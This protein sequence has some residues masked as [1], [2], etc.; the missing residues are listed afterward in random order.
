VYTE[1][2]WGSFHKEWEILKK[3]QT[4]KQREGNISSP[5]PL[6]TYTPSHLPFFHSVP[7]SLLFFIAILQA[8]TLT[9]T[10]TDALSLLL[11]APFSQH[12]LCTTET[13]DCFSSGCSIQWNWFFSALA[14]AVPATNQAAS[15]QPPL[16]CLWLYP[17]PFPPALYSRY[18]LPLSVRHVFLQ[19]PACGGMKKREMVFWGRGDEAAV[20]HSTSNRLVLVSLMLFFT[21]SHRWKELALCLIKVYSSLWWC[22]TPWSLDWLTDC[23]GLM[24]ET[25][26]EKRQVRNR[27]GEKNTINNLLYL[28]TSVKFLFK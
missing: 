28:H 2:A 8:Y 26:P 23:G 9:C 25:V 16:Y 7:P 14:H 15:D 1:A 24:Y 12:P 17:L 11:R 5:F 6:S 27:Y 3:L 18:W 10:M 4:G 13:F 19:S 20:D 21:R 22:V